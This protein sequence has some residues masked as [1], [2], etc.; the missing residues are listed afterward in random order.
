MSLRT[1]FGKRFRR[2]SFITP[3][4]LAQILVTAPGV[5]ASGSWTTLA[6]SPKSNQELGG[7]AAPCPGGTID[8]GCIY[9]EGGGSSRHS[10]LIY[11]TW[12]NIWTTGADLPTGRYLL[13]V[14]AARA[15]FGASGIWIYAIDGYDTGDNV[16]EGYNPNKNTWTS[17][18]PDPTPRTNLG[19]AAGVCPGGTVARGCIYAVDGYAGGTVLGT[20]EAFNTFNNTWTSLTSDP[21]PRED[22][23][24]AAARCPF[25]QGGTCI[26]S[27]GGFAPFSRLNTA[28]AFNPKTNSWTTLAPMLTA[29]RGPGAAA[30][31]CPGGTVPDGCVYV[32][33]GG[34]LSGY[35]NVVEGYN[36]FNNTWFT[37]TPDP[38]SR[39]DLAVIAARAPFGGSGTRIYAIDGNNGSTLN[40]NEALTP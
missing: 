4:V 39:N 16:V 14:T 24:V 15:P 27:F 38:V 17:F 2:W 13:A 40:T 34:G 10:N 12:T 7:A 37:E 18:S 26:Y 20:T 22:P 9:L 23:G 1:R 8:G 31:P 29:R 19:A 11:S 36:T 25:N 32:V 35:L 28:E 5:S 30:A 3:L 21:T 6:P 33:D